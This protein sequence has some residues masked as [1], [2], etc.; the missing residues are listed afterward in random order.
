MTQDKNPLL[1]RMKRAS[2]IIAINLAV[3]VVIV[4]ILSFWVTPN[5]L[6][7]VTDHD[8]RV[9]VAN[10]VGEDADA[11][12]TQLAEQGLNPLVIDTIF[13]DGHKPGVVLDQLP[14]GNLPVKPGRN[15]YLTIN[16]YTTQSFAFPD[17]VQQSSRQAR[18]ELDDQYFVVDSV[19]YE[20]YKFDDLVL[21]VYAS[22]TQTPMV[23]GK[24][25]PKRTHVVLVVGSTTVSVEAENDETEDA[26]FE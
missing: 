1:K 3:M 18:S 10:V 15:V 5:F 13:S 24:E 26:F 20:P 4:C 9:I 8:A 21:N 2:I 11:A 14:E 17:V 7:E 23:V 12:V 19:I 22:G 16:S 25:Y 6:H